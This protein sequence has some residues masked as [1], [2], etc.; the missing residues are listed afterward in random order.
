MPNTIEY[1]SVPEIMIYATADGWSELGLTWLPE[2]LPRIFGH[3]NYF[4]DL[5]PLYGIEP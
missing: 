2:W 5:E 3:S 4:F 1:Q